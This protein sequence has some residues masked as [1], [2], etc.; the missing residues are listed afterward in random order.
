VARF[1]ARFERRHL[2]AR[3]VCPE[4]GRIAYYRCY[5][6]GP[7][8]RVRGRPKAHQCHCGAWA[9]YWGFTSKYKGTVPHAQGGRWMRHCQ[10]CGKPTEHARWREGDPV[11]CMECGRQRYLDDEEEASR[12]AVEVASEDIWGK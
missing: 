6:D 5:L 11:M 8:E 4:C 2:M 10:D 7:G 9:E 12:E 1:L 3:Y